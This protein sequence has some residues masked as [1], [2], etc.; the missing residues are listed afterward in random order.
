MT[1]PD[2]H[3][4]R[5]RFYIEFRADDSVGSLRIVEAQAASS[6]IRVSGRTSI[7]PIVRASRANFLVSGKIDIDRHIER[8]D[9]T[10]E[11]PEPLRRRPQS[12]GRVDW[13]SGHRGQ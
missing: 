6:T 11:T 9:R 10:L 4:G 1:G 8:G 3:I 12:A 5:A 7:N 13:R 2:R